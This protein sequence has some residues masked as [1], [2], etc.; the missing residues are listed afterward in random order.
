[1]LKMILPLIAMGLVGCADVATTTLKYQ[2]PNGG[3]LTVAFPKEMDASN[4]K[5]DL[6]A[7]QGTVHLSADWLKTRNTDTIKAQAAREKGDL[8]AASKLTDAIAAGVAKGIVA[9]AV[10]GVTGGIIP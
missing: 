8:E 7:K 3:G 1:M 2:M 6:D 4:F 5:L 10:K 9:G